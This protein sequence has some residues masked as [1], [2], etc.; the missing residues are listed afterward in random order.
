MKKVTKHIKNID[1]HFNS[2]SDTEKHDLTIRLEK[3]LN[4]MILQN[5]YTPEE[6]LNKTEEMMSQFLTV[7]EY[8]D[9]N[10]IP[11]QPKNVSVDYKTDP[12]LT[13]K[14]MGMRAVNDEFASMAENVG[15]A[16]AGNGSGMGAV[17]T[18]SPSSSPGQ[19][20]GSNFST[21]TSGDSIG[22]GGTVGSGDVGV[23]LYNATSKR[24]SRRKE[25]TKAKVKDM[26]KKM[27]KNIN[28]TF[29]I[30]D[31]KQGGNIKSFSEYSKKK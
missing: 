19:T 4:V 23:G 14:D 18:A 29:D 22:G 3:L 2:P 27:A 12:V 5:Y 1:E 20:T 21:P 8:E 31:Y 6:L 30:K 16:S 26:A 25:K 15:T 11:G 24:K 17:V 7:A 9:T 28:N 13:N 10:K